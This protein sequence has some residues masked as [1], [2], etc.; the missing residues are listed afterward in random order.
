MADPLVRD[1]LKRE[2]DK[3]E[4]RGYADNG[5]AAFKEAAAGFMQKVFGVTLDPATEVNHAIGSKPALAML[6]AA[7][8]NPGDVTLMTVPGYPVAGTHTRLLRRR[9]PQPAAAGRERL[10]PRPGGDPGRRPPAGQAA[11]HQLPQQ[12]DRGDGDARL[13][14]PRHRLRPHQPDRRRAGRRPHPAQLRRPAAELPPGRRGPGGRRRGPLDV[15]GL[16]HDRLAHGLRGRPPEDRAGVRR[17]EG[18]LR[19]RAS[20]WRSSRRPRTA[21]RAPRDR[22]RDAREVP[23]PARQAGR[24]P[25]NEVGFQAKMPSGT[26]F[27]YAQAPSGCTGQDVRQR[28]GGVAVPHHRAVGLL[29]AVGRRRRVP[30]L[31]GRR[32]W[33]RTRPRR[34]P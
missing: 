22:R 24:A 29:R 17:R 23:P 13:L 9:G 25:S 15:E 31:L 16:Q 12:P 33:P 28:R 18:Q 8:I 2:V 10:L 21:L 3:L 6:P 20:S 19:L 4:N 7:F 30:A 11:G 14:P 34:T 27:L 5:I 32:T 26:Y 1:A